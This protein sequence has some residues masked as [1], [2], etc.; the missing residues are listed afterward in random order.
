MT[1][2]PATVKKT[3]LCS[4]NVAGLRGPGD[5]NVSCAGGTQDGIA[6]TSTII[7]TSEVSRKRKNGHTDAKT[8]SK[9]HLSEVCEGKAGEAAHQKDLLR[10]KDGIDA[11]NTVVRHENDKATA[12]EQVRKQSSQKLDLETFLQRKKPF[13]A[14][15]RRWNSLSWPT[16]CYSDQSYLTKSLDEA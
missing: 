4:V 3:L 2:P 16:T 7:T 1:T 8:S 14:L 15:V 13:S 10:I 12:L 11:Q 6:M 9:R 5:I